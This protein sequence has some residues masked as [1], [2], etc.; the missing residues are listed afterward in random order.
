M[1]ISNGLFSVSLDFGVGIFAGDSRW[2]AIGVRTNGG[3]AFSA[4]AGRQ[5]VTPSPYAIHAA[6]AVT[7]SNATTATTMPWSGLSGMP[8]G[9]ADAVD[10][11]TTYTAGPGLT[12][13]GTEFSAQFAGSGAAASVARSDHNHSAADVVSGTLAD[14]RLSTNVCLVGHSPTFSG[15]VTAGGDLQAARLKVG[16]GHTLTGT[17]ATIGGGSNNT[18][19]AVGD[20]VGGGWWNQAQGGYSVVGGGEANT[21]SGYHAAVLGGWQNKATNDYATVAGGAW[22]YAGGAGAFV[23]G[24]GW[25]GLT[26]AGN[27][28]SGDASTVGG[29]LDNFIGTNGAWATIGGGRRNTI[30]E[31]TDMSTIAGGG[32]NLIWA[33]AD[34]STIGGGWNNQ[35]EALSSYST[36]AGGSLNHIRSNVLNATMGGGYANYIQDRSDFATIG[37]GHG[38]SI[39]PDSV[40]ATIPGGR[41]NY[42]AGAYSFAAGR[43]AKAMQDGAFVWADSTDTNFASTGANQFLI[44]ANGGVGIGTNSPQTALHVAGTVRASAF[45]GDGSAL[46]SLSAG[47]LDSGTVPDARLSANVALL[48]SS[49]TF[50]GTV[51]AGGGL[52]AGGDVQG[53]RLKVGTGHTLSGALASIGG[54]FGNTASGYHAFVGGGSGNIASG[55]AAVVAGGDLNAATNVHSTVGGGNQN[56]AWGDAATVSGGNVNTAS[57]AFATVAGGEQNVASGPGAFVGGGGYNGS[58]VA[59]NVASGPASTVGGGYANTVH[60]N[61][62]YATTGGGYYNTIR[63]NAHYATIAGGST[64]TIQ[65]DVVYATI[66]GGTHNTIDTNAACATIGGGG[67]NTIQVNGYSTTIAGGTYNTIQTNASYGTIAGGSRATIHSDAVCATIGGGGMNTIQTNAWSATISGGVTN[68]I[69]PNAA[70]AT[71]GGGGY[72]RI[73][74]NANCATIPGGALNSATSYAF[75]AG[76]RAKAN[77]NGAFVWAD[78]TEAD[79][80][81]TR[82]DEFN[83]RAAGGVRIESGLGIGLNAQNSPLITRGYDP[84]TSGAYTGLGRWGL[85]ME[86]FHLVIGIPNL[87]WRNFQVAKYELD[88]SRTPLATIDQAGNLTIAGTYYPISDRNAKENFAPVDSRGCAG[89][90]GGAA[91]QAVELQTG[92]AAC[93][94]SARWRRISTPRSAWARTTNTSPPW[95]PTAWRWRR[96]RD[97][98]K[99]WK[100]E[101]RKQRAG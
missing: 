49:P 33:D 2:L 72:N 59:G 88:G 14:A 48:N 6:D 42:A 4:L 71:I 78:S 13:A 89:E 62:Y 51:T 90:S 93:R 79:F 68:T 92:R 58:T 55:Y 25:D 31:F 65:A 101:G 37:G 20:A 35:I 21:A 16:T 95:T 44:R 46:T 74:P 94:I 22:N 70:Y 75:A 11:D 15:T 40:Y 98:M 91:H 32:D 39:W 96:S 67:L 84:F 43:R 54:G 28:A 17:L 5:A 100:V 26:V 87:E 63:P 10:N 83:I 80:A 60:T 45:Q 53:T 50:S 81:S 3:G 69:E 24:G 7:A 99:K 61:A 23:G 64:N 82:N 30:K 86:P 85:F 18:A 19:S 34:G 29:G 77:H 52:T 36:I 8:V 97:S 66:A 1:S 57:G 9:F 73:H 38:N 27:V 41:L 56:K 47:N 76:Y 12:L